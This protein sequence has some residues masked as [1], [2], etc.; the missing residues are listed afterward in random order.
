MVEEEILH[1]LLQEDV[2]LRQG[3]ALANSHCCLK[4]IFHLV[5]DGY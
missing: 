1:N 3:A 4:G 2:E 5:V